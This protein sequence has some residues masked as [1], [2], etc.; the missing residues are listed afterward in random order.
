MS[1]NMHYT[2]LLYVDILKFIDLVYFMAY[3][4]TRA[5]MIYWNNVQI[6]S[7][8][9]SELNYISM[10]MVYFEGSY[11]RKYVIVTHTVA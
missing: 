7:L 4:H 11:I 3:P 5:W 9:V 8:L 1:S 6:R 2:N 10:M